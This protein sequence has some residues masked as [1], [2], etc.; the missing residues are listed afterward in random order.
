MNRAIRPVGKVRRVVR[1]LDEFAADDFVAGGS[2][3]VQRDARLAFRRRA[4]NKLE[5]LNKSENGRLW[6]ENVRG[7][8]S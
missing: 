3:P 7:E 4:I 8:I 5:R 2:R 1:I 6:R